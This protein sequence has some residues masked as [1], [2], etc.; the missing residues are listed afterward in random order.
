[1]PRVALFF[2]QLGFISA[3]ITYYISSADGN[4]SAAGTSA[5][6]PWRS[7]ANLASRVHGDDTVLLKRGD[8]WYDEQTL[9]IPFFSGRLSSY[10]NETI[11]RPAIMFGRGN[12]RDATT[13]LEF[14]YPVHA[15]VEEIHMSGCAVGIHVFAPKVQDK[16]GILIQRCGFADIRQPYGVYQPSNSFWGIAIHVG[17]M[18]NVTI[19]NNFGVRLDTFFS[20]DRGAAPVDGLVLDSNTVAQCGDNCYL[21]GGHNMH[22]RNSVFLRDTPASL[23]MY[24]TTD[25]IV[26]TVTGNNSIE[27]NDFNQRGEYMGGPDG[28]AIDFETDAVGFTIRGN[29]ISRSFG[30]GLM[31]FGHQSTSTD[32]SII[33]N[34]FLSAGCVQTAGDRAGLAFMCPNGHK[35]SGTVSGNTFFNCPGVPAFYS[36]PK[37]PGC[38]DAVVRTNN[39]I[40]NATPTAADLTP[41]VMNTTPARHRKLRTAMLLPWLLPFALSAHC[42]SLSL[43]AAFRFSSCR[44]LLTCHSSTSAHPHPTPY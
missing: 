25:V 44:W 35:P 13:C 27:N 15:T 34:A 14:L 6:S 19:K 29:T 7:F 9:R 41:Q 30:A 23:F 2:A 18:K 16:S 5:I 11:A 8:V 17:A 20:S 24:G 32:F 10:G 26:G 33:G 1:M 21:L 31:V 36:N 38:S 43:L 37:V 12:G 40:V 4:D 22:L 42:L 3:S 39:K 28:C